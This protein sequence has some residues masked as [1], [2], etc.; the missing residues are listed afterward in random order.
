MKSAIEIMKL[1]AGDAAR[2]FLQRVPAQ[3]VRA[4]FAG[5]SV[6]RGEVWSAPEEGRLA[7]YS[8]IDL[9]VV[10]AEGADLNRA[11]WAAQEA[12][13]ALPR[14]LEGVVFHRGVDFGIYSFDD[15]RAQPVR[16]GTVDLAEHHV[17]LHG[18]RS[19]L[20]ALRRDASYPMATSEALYLLE[21]RAWDALEARAETTQGRASLRAY[22]TAAKVVLDVVSAHLIAE[23]RYRA[24]YRE[25]IAEYAA[26]A[27]MQVS[28]RVRDAA[29]SAERFRSGD[30]SSRLDPQT[31]LTMVAET[32]CAL[33]PSIL[34]G[35]D[36][37]AHDVPALVATRCRQGAWKDNFREFVRLRRAAGLPLGGAL[38]VG[39]RYA[40]LSP[41]AALRT[42]AVV[43]A[44]AE[45]AGNP[46]LSFHTAYVSRLTS[47][48]GCREGNLD[49]RARAAYRA[50]S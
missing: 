17:W 36:A 14:T 18:D 19:L 5:G 33:A 32:W 10:L 30:T 20:E 40:T 35:R 22:A 31:A 4:L 49:E 41:R 6:G 44:L 1:R 8:D 29:A 16:P 42:H 7:V 26:R 34:W 37:E 39:W 43:R 28:K 12:D 46:A 11:R 2:E 21:H 3:S 48:F 25:R 45:A 9:Y 50:V 23:G 15:L 13:A 27:P 24:T 38:A 47:C